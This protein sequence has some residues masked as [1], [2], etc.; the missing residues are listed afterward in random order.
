MGKNNDLNQ[1]CIC[2]HTKESHT[3]GGDCMGSWERL[4]GGGGMH[5]PCSCKKFEPVSTI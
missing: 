4:A 2:G 3:V 5:L 1:K